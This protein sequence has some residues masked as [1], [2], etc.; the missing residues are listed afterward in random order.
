MM[1]NSKVQEDIDHEDDYSNSVEDINDH[2]FEDPNIQQVHHGALNEV[3]LGA[4]R[5][6]HSTKKSDTIQEDIEYI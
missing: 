5:N 3:T 2:L 4:E 6:T 1:G